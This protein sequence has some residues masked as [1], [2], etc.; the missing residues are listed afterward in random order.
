[1]SWYRVASSYAITRY[2][3]AVL[4]GWF[5]LGLLL[6]FLSPSWDQVA[7]DG[8]FAFMPPE[9]P[10]LQGQAWLDAGFPEQRSKSQLAIILARPE[11][12]LNEADLAIGLDVGR[13]LQHQLA[14]VCWQLAESAESSERRQQLLDKALES[15]HQS[16]ELDQQLANN[17][18]TFSD[19]STIRKNLDR[20]AIAYWDRSQ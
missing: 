7:K 6:H 19:N 11:S 15:L 16:I 18:A 13:R 8:D 20:L 10:S 2:W 5:S 4:L 12:P 17:L 3:P 14:Q 1:M 9:M